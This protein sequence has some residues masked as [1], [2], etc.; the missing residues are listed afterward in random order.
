MSLHTVTQDEE[1]VTLS[2]SLLP[3]VCRPVP[4]IKVYRCLGKIK[5]KVRLEDGNG[6]IR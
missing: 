3:A 6:L 2:G 4:I 1:A 5:V